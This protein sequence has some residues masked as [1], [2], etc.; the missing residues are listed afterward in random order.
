MDSPDYS[1][2]CGAQLPIRIDSPGPPDPLQIGVV[3]NYRTE[4]GRE[5]QAAFTLPKGKSVPLDELVGALK[6]V[7]RLIEADRE[8][9]GW[10]WEEKI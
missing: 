7:T 8:Q 5:R 2:H 1:N 4:G 9:C 6:L 10:E 3:L